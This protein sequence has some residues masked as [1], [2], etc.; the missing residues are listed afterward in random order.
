MQHLDVGTLQVTYQ[1]KIVT[2]AMFSVLL[3]K[4]IVTGKQWLSFL[5]LMVGV[6]FVQ[7]N[8]AE[9]SP[10]NDLEVNYTFGI[11]CVLISS[12]TSGFAGVFLEKLIKNQKY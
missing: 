8:P 7:F 11:T 1:L 12:I 2:T 6:T 3:L 9:L 5:L 4:K 10:S